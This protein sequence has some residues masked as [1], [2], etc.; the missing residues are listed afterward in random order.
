MKGEDGINITIHDSVH[1]RDSE[2]LLVEEM[3]K[4]RFFGCDLQVYGTVGEEELFLIPGQ[5]VEGVAGVEDGRNNRAGLDRYSGGLDLP[6]C[7]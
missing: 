6:Q 7:L 2:W 3:L 1:C 5:D 4:G